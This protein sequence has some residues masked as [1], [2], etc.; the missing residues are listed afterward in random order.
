MTDWHGPGNEAFDIPLLKPNERLTNVG[1]H[2][3]FSF[4]L[5]FSVFRAIKIES[6][7]GDPKFSLQR[8]QLQQ[9][10]LPPKHPKMA[11]L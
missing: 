4:Y 1:L 2:T 11:H 5:Q 3:N 9:S 8:N 6:V 10:L 7:N